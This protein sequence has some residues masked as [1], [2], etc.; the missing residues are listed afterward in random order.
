MNY[1]SMAAEDE[2]LN[3]VTN[4]SRRRLL[5]TEEQQQQAQQ[6]ASVRRFQS[7]TNGIPPLDTNGGVYTNVF[8][9]S[10]ILLKM[11]KRRK[12]RR[13]KKNENVEQLPIAER[14]TEAP[15]RSRS[16]VYTMLNSKSRQSQAVIYKN[17]MSPIIVIDLAFFVFSTDPRYKHHHIFYLE[18]GIASCIFML[19]YIARLVTIT[20]G[21]KYGQMGA[22]KGRLR[23]MMSFHALIDAFATFPFFIEFVTDFNL[24]HLTYLRFFRLLRILR[25]DSLGQAMDSLSRVIFYN[26]E[27]LYVAGVMAT[28]LIMFTAVLMY[29]LRPQGG[30]LSDDGDEWSISTTIYYSTLMLTGQG[31]PEGDLPWYT[32]VVV[33]MTGLFSIGMFAIPASMLTWGFEAEAQRVALKTRRRYLQKI[34][35]DVPSSSSSSSSSSDDCNGYHSASSSDEEYLKLIAG[36]GEDENKGGEKQDKEAEEALR[37]MRELIIMFQDADTDGSGSISKEEFLRLASPILPKGVPNNV[38][39]EHSAVDDIEQLTSTLLLKRVNRLEAKLDETNNRLDRL[40][41]LL[42]S[43]DK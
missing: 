36:G 12:K 21:R 43:N 33:L 20:E 19:E 37:K 28:G 11:K 35:G 41:S 17:M 38:Y 16:C 8:R 14:L 31:G 3:S 24:P 2:P 9:R 4:Y 13:K 26:R 22:L 29:Y 15:A 39:D 23:Y 27:I 7:S 6:G 32:Q 30:D 25:T 5:N 18:E 40:L 42:E 34:S 10:D 1:G